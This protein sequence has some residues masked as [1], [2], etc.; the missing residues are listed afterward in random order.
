MS[1]EQLITASSWTRVDVE[2]KIKQLGKWFH[3][4]DLNGVQTAPDHF[5]G[6]YPNVKWSRLQNFIPV[7]L[8]GKSVLDIG[9]NAGFYSLQMKRRGA[10]RVLAID[11]DPDYLVQARFAAEVMGL[12]IEFREMSAFETPSLK[13]QF[14]LVLFMG[15]LYHLRYPLLALDL[16]AEY[17]VKDRFIFQSLTRG[18]DEVALLED[19]Y[20]FDETRVFNQPGFPRLHFI[21]KSYS[22]DPT[23]WWIPNRACA[24]AMI[25]SAGLEIEARA[26]ADT[27]VCRRVD[28]GERSKYLEELL[29]ATR[30]L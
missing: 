18:S 8:R 11:S 2:A 7:D 22:L 25:R 19:D 23:N 1:A 29:E 30:K 6:D 20:P 24:E 15:V 9:C 3:N 17:V 5:L 27:Y 4:L 26:D 28:N 16:L 12:E 10:E 21:E 13:E 14:D